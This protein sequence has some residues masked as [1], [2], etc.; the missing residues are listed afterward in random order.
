MPAR[1]KLR[2]HKHAA[3]RNAPLYKALS[4]P[5]RYRIMMVLGEVEASPKELGELLDEPFHRVCEH[6]R[7]LR[8]AGVIE[9]VDED[10]KHG[11]VQHIYKATVRPLLE[12]EEWAHLPKLVQEAGSVATLGVI[13]NEAA[14]AV[15]AGTFDSHPRRALLQK[16]LI[17][18]EQGFAEADDSA[19]RHLDELNRIAAES[20]ARLVEAGEEGMAIK[21][22]TIV[23][24]AAP[25]PQS[26]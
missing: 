13:F 12:A 18:D 1:S 22:A 16:P 19:L 2:E 24:P 14:A 9:L 8:D 17:V 10:T 7:V 5:L 6:V 20:A 11:G 25:S 4:H 21:T 23:H 26:A 3:G 15:K